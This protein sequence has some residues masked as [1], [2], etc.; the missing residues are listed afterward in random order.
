MEDIGSKFDK[1]LTAYSVDMK[2]LMQNSAK[3][4]LHKEKLLFR[5]GSLEPSVI[6]DKKNFDRRARQ[7]LLR[8]NHHEIIHADENF[9][10]SELHSTDDE[11]S[12]E[13]K[14]KLRKLRQQQELISKQIN[15]TLKNL[16]K[17]KIIFDQEK[18]NDDESFWYNDSTGQRVYFDPKIEKSNFRHHDSKHLAENIDRLYKLSKSDKNKNISKKT[19]KLKSMMKKYLLNSIKDKTS[20]N[21]H[22]RINKFK[23]DPQLNR[24]KS[25]Q[26]RSSLNLIRLSLNPIE[27]KENNGENVKK[28]V[29]ISH[30][31]F[32]IEPSR[33]FKS[34]VVDECDAK[35]SSN[36]TCSS[37]SLGEKESKSVN[38]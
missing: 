6:N 13:D 33:N 19:K 8:S 21:S 34:S 17:N 11:D 29:Q 4:F 25:R 30:N 15:D 35:N 38:Y 7:I 20:I 2:L 23:S 3:S 14:T 26:K 22:Y 12:I 10:P 27:L 16:R 32:L 1:F 36:I 37:N 28:R 9:F 24:I 31:L 18:N 5:T